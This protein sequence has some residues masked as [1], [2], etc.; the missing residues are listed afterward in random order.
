MIF[1]QT[2]T[3]IASPPWSRLGNRCRRSTHNSAAANVWPG[4]GFSNAFLAVGVVLAAGLRVGVFSRP[5]EIAQAPFLIL[6]LDGS[7]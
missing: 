5:D 3:K 2:T 4:T 1:L 6:K 7:N